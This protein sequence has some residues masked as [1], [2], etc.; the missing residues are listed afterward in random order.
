MSMGRSCK[1]RGGT[2]CVSSC[3]MLWTAVVA[4]QPVTREDGGLPMY[5]VVFALHTNTYT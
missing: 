2:L 3:G 1:G 5:L 4:V